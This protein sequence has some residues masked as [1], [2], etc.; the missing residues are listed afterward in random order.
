MKDIEHPVQENKQKTSEFLA[1]KIEGYVV[2][3]L[4]SSYFRQ[5][6]NNATVPTATGLLFAN[7]GDSVKFKFKH[8][9]DPED[10]VSDYINVHI[11]NR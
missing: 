9:A 8:F 5:N 11:Y 1:C 4:I 10:V 2:T 7:D 3:F 6:Q